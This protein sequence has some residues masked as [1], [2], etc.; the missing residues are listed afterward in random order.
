MIK[1]QELFFYPPY[2]PDLVSKKFNLSAGNRYDFKE[3]MITKIEEFCEELDKLFN[4]KGIEML[5][6]RCNDCIILDE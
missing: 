2:S 1:L 6:R 3:E 5:A 4:K